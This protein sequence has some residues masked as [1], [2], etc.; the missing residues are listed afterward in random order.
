MCDE[1][2]ELKRD[3]ELGAANDDHP[4]AAN[5]DRVDDKD[6]SSEEMVVI[7]RPYITLRN[8]KRLYAAQKGLK[9]FCFEVPASKVR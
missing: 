3:T 4:T 5:D 7:C 9:A 8:G 1:P 6:S 2:K